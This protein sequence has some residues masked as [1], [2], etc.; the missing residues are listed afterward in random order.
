MDTNKEIKELVR[1][2]LDIL[3]E[4]KKY[5]KDINDRIKII[6]IQIKEAAQ[7]D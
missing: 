5:N 4:K 7:E 1:E 6:D 3:E 2:K